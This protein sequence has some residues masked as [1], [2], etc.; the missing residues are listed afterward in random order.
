MTAFAVVRSDTSGHA[1]VASAVGN[2]VQWK[3]VVGSDGSEASLSAEP[4]TFQLGSAVQ[5]ICWH[6]SGDYLGI[7]SDDRQISILN[8]TNVEV[9]ASS[10]VKRR[11]IAIQ[12]CSTLRDN[13]DLVVGDAVGDVFHLSSNVLSSSLGHLLELKSMVRAFFL[14]SMAGGCD[15]RTNLP[16]M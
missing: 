8:V 5:A 1:R 14:L 13:L 9:V 7:V 6:A 15:R 11:P 16:D 2:K 3:D 4:K 12:F 10:Q